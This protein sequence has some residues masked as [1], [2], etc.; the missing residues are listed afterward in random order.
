MRR[1]DR[2]RRAAL[3]LLLGCV[4]SYVQASAARAQ[5]VLMEQVSSYFDWEYDLDGRVAAFEP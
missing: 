4:L 5:F 3:G 2:G 1:P